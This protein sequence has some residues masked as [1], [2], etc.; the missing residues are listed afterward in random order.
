M[1]LRRERRTV[2]MCLKFLQNSGLI[3]LGFD[4]QNLHLVLK[5]LAFLFEH[6]HCHR[7][8]SLVISPCFYCGDSILLRSLIILHKAR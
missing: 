2:L 7:S 1:V 8:I 6:L 4:L 5:S 3:R